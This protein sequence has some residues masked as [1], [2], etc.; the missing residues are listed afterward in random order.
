MRGGGGKGQTTTSPRV[1]REPRRT[2]RRHQCRAV[3]GITCTQDSSDESGDY[4]SRIL[5][6]R[7]SSNRRS[8]ITRRSGP[9]LN[10]LVACR[11]VQICTEFLKG[12]VQSIQLFNYLSKLLLR[13]TAKQYSKAFSLYFFD[14]DSRGKSSSEKDGK[15][16]SHAKVFSTSVR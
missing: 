16:A 6:E 9:A 13:N 8:N 2:Q 14:R 10:T 12:R 4:A 3:F 5:D 1:Q 7:A 15:K 11:Y